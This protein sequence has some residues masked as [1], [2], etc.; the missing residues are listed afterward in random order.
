MAYDMYLVIPDIPGEAKGLENGIELYSFSIGASNP[1]TVGS[2]TGGISAG[3]VSL[4]S[5][6][7][8]KQ[9]DKA[10]AKLFLAA[11]QGTHIPSM[12]VHMRK[13]TGTGGQTDFLVYEFTEVMVES[14]QWGG[15]AGG[16]DTPSETVS[17]AFA[18]I[19]ITY[20]AQ[21]AD[22]ALAV[23]GEATWDQTTVKNA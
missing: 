8:T 11:C 17:F 15:S 21:G 4:T 2:A 3:K 1:V 14:I 16:T 12:K 9:T 10:S 19:H 13:Q 6:T 7:V 20:S 22:G 18:K 5:F 23:A